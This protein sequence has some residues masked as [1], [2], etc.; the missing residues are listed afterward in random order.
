MMELQEFENWLIAYKAAW[1][2]QDEA[3]IENIFA[4]DAVY[5]ETPYSAPRE[6]FAAIRDYWRQGPVEDQRE[7][8]FQYKIWE[9][10]GEI[11][12]AH[13]RC[14]FVRR[15]SHERVELDGIFHCTFSD[16]AADPRT[17]GEFRAWWHAKTSSLGDI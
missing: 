7:I 10:T 3:A 2:N 5:F 8:S 17:C 15:S 14:G 9:V 1:E 4:E 16:D 12:I 13:W 6:G 11:G